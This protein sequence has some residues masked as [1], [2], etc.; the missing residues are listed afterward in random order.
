MEEV[1]AQVEQPKEVKTIVAEVILA[2]PTKFMNLSGG[3]V[4][5]LAST[6]N[7]PFENILVLVDDIAF[8]LG[9]SR[10]RYGGSGGQKGMEDI[11]NRLGTEKIARLRIGVGMLR[12]GEDKASF[13]L[14]RFPMESAQTISDVTDNAAGIA[15]MWME[16]GTMYTMNAANK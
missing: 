6:Y 13:V 10:L 8:E 1:L 7:V 4:R 9:K 2:K 14:K 12:P 16:C 5:A 15:A 3:C 11:I